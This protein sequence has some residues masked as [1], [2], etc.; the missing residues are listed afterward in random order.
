M[1]RIHVLQEF[2]LKDLP[3]QE[4]LQLGYSVRNQG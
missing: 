4:R 2:Q 1:L 3:E